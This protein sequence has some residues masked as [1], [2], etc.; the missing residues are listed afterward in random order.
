MPVHTEPVSRRRELVTSCHPAKC[1]G[2]RRAHPDKKH[3]KHNEP[4]RAYK[5]SLMSQHSL[6]SNE[7]PRKR[8]GRNGPNEDHRSGAETP[9]PSQK[10]R[11]SAQP[12]TTVARRSD[13]H[14]TAR[15][16]TSDQQ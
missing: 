5:S 10:K 15:D 8:I 11:H 12:Q 2:E 9:L 7:L 1:G 14:P 16:L 3:L 4:L 13:L 6:G